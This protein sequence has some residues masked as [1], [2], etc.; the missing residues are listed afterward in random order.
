MPVIC[1]NPTDDIDAELLQKLNLQ[2]QDI[3]IFISD[4]ILN[5]KIEKFVGKKA[6]GDLTDDS[7]I[8]TASS[9]AYCGIFIE[10]EE[11]SQRSVF[12]EAIKNSSLQRIIWTSPYA[13]SEELTDMKNLIYIISRDKKLSHDVSETEILILSLMVRFKITVLSHPNCEV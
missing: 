3:R 13:P 7:H 4:H 11:I 10:S 2:N 5:D 6:V 12:I 8:S 9:G 1:I